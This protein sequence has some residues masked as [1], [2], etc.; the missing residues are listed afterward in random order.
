MESY[1]SIITHLNKARCD[2]LKLKKHDLSKYPMVCRAEQLKERFMT[3]AF[4][5]DSPS[6]II[7]QLNSRVMG[8]YEAKKAVAISAI[9]A[10]NS[11][12]QSR[13]GHRAGTGAIPLL[14]GPPGSGKTFLL[15][16]LAESMNIPFETLDLNCVCPSGGWSGTSIESHTRT[17][18]AKNPD[19]LVVVELANLDAIKI[20]EASKQADDHYLRIQNSI[21]PLLKKQYA[22]TEYWI[23]VVTGDFSNLHAR[24]R[25]EQDKKDKLIS[26]GIQKRILNCVNSV[27]E[28]EPITDEKLI[29]RLFEES[30]LTSQIKEVLS[31]TD[32]TLKLSLEEEN[33]I[34][35][36]FK[37]SGFY[38]T[39]ELFNDI[40]TN[41]LLT[42]PDSCICIEELP[43]VK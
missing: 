16:S 2:W 15:S 36:C 38:K 31:Y 8:L 43:D 37:S 20:D 10:E 1:S 41:Y 30:S 33:Q 6:A 13:K 28:L 3:Q 5:F 42:L 26:L 40:C 4:P 17:I 9:L 39:Q 18:Q 24:C 27:I 7:R 23:M 25:E 19:R 34:I 12:I 35:T 14:I 29:L 32:K 21:I 11:Y 22:G